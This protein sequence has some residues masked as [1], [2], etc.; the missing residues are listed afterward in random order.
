MALHP[1]WD[2]DLG[3]GQGLVSD[4]LKAFRKQCEE[5]PLTNQQRKKALEKYPLPAIAELRPPKLDMTVKILV[6]KPVSAHD[7][8][9]YRNFRL[10]VWTPVL[11]CWP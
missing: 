1:D 9:G 6:S 8:T 4:Q 3:P 11:P 10:G 2:I 5:S 7:V